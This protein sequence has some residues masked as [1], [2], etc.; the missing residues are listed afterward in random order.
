MKFSGSNLCSITSIKAV[1]A[2]SDKTKAEDYVYNQ[3]FVPYVS[4]DIVSVYLDDPSLDITKGY[5]FYFNA[6]QV[7][8]KS[9]YRELSN[10]EI[11]HPIEKFHKDSTCSDS[12]PLCCNNDNIY[13]RVYVPCNRC[14]DDNMLKS[15][16]TAVLQLNDF[17]SGSSD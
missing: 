2:F 3:Q 14:N 15:F 12:D 7:D 9:D 6:K 1:A 4:Y 5:V 10:D 17:V 11:R 13:Y 8:F 16:K